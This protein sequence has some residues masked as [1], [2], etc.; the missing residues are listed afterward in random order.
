MKEKYP[1]LIGHSTRACKKLFTMEQVADFICEQGL[2]GEVTIETPEGLMLIS[3]YGIYLDKVTD[4]EYR[5]KL[6]E[7]LEPKQHALEKA[8]FGFAFGEILLNLTVRKGKKT[9][10]EYERLRRQAI[11]LRDMYPPGTRVECLYMSDPFAPVPSGTK[12]TVELTED[13]IT[14]WDIEGKSSPPENMPKGNINSYRDPSGFALDTHKMQIADLIDAIKNDRRPLVD[15][16]E[17]RKPVD[18]ILGAYQSSKTKKTV[19]I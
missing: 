6:L 4:M 13:V 17:G 3:T 11:V 14:R 2:Y 12:G 5:E 9:M 10:N 15:V 19:F 1:V 16:Y 8:E 18:I 7:I